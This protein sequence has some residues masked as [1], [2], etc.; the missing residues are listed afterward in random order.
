MKIKTKLY[1]S[2]CV[3]IGLI[4]LLIAFSLF[5]SSGMKKQLE[6]N[7]FASELS[8][9]IGELVLVTD[10]YLAYH[11]ERNAQQWEIKYE[12]ILKIVP[13]EQAQLFGH[14]QTDLESLHS[15]FLSLVSAAQERYQVGKDNDSGKEVEHIS[16]LEER[17]VGRIRLI[18]N[19]IMVD[20]FNISQNALFQIE[21]LERKEDTIELAVALLLICLIAV[22]SYF[23]IRKITR[24]LRGFVESAAII[25]KGNLEH[26]MKVQN[27]D[28]DGRP[29]DEIGEFSVSFKSMTRKLIQSIEDLQSEVLERKRAEQDLLKERTLLKTIID[30]IPVMLTHYSPDAH[31]LY[32][33]KEFEKIVGWKTEE[34]QDIDM[35][36]K[37]YP[38]PD[39]RQQ[40]AEYMQKASTEWREFRVQI[41]VKKRYTL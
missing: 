4:G 22:S 20:S 23:T 21:N 12:E 18:S 37:V 30:N 40:A 10:E 2:A 29:R 39:Y 17:L 34:V 28:S 19:K 41:N 7:R 38:D 3:I 16:I 36:E 1:L 13:N 14:L 6:K 24:P 26:Q 31:M 5:F 15:S 35:M 32:L 11:Y 27:L 25:E 33:N 9:K 8:R